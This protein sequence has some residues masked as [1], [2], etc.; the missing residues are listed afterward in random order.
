MRVSIFFVV[1]I[2]ACYDLGQLSKLQFFASDLSL[3]GINV[4]GALFIGGDCIVGFGKGFEEACV[5]LCR[6]A[7]LLFGCHDWIDDSSDV[8]ELAKC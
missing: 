3:K 1:G 7:D 6:V 2:F 5:L 4:A 8:F